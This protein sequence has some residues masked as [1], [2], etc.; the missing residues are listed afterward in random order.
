MSDSGPTDDV[1]TVQRILAWTTDYLTKSGVAA[2][3]LEAELL[4]GHA[5]QC[6]RVRLYTDYDIPMTDTERARMRE[7]VQRRATREPLAYIT[8]KREFYGRNF[9]V[10]I[11]VLI[12]R[13]ETET[14]VDLA[15]EQISDDRPSQFAEVGFG[16]GCITITLAVQKA[17]CRVTASDISEVCCQYAARNAATYEVADR[18][19]FVH[20][21]G[22]EAVKLS[23]T[24]VR[25]DG[26]ISNPPYV[27]DHELQELQPEVA[28]YE[29]HDALFSGSDGL[30]LIRRLIPESLDILKPG[31]WIGLEC[32]PAQ[33]GEVCR[34]MT[35]SGFT[36]PQIH[37]DHR[38]VDRI[39]TAIKKGNTC[40]DK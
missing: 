37:Q 3:R 25:Y 15:L 28:E 9:E 24:D 2:A 6:P 29:P 27:C 4:C 23:Q 18:I 32:D 22:L 5:R 17:K 35:D 21:N 33:C 38:N 39:V 16:S 13:P 19:Q 8:G 31:G 30:D 40:A 26:I 10:G 34:L 36:K 7:Y 1:W 14:L 12:P 20:G 11:G